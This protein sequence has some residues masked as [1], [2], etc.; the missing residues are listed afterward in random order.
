MRE[1]HFIEARFGRLLGWFERRLDP[2]PEGREQAAATQWF[3]YVRESIGKDWPL[4]VL[5]LI[6]AAGLAIAELGLIGMIGRLIDALASS[7]DERS[8]DEFMAQHGMLV[9]GLIGFAL[10]VP[11]FATLNRLLLWQ[12]TTA[13]F[14]GRLRWQGHRWLL[15]QDMGFYG[16]EFAGRV[17]SRLMQGS[18]ATREVV[19]TTA[20]ICANFLTWILGSILLVATMDV[21]LAWPFLLFLALWAVKL[22]WFVPRLSRVARRQADAR[23]LMTGRIVDSYTN[24]NAVKLFGEGEQEATYAK[25]A[26]RDFLH[27]VYP[28][29]RLVT[30][31]FGLLDLIN[32]ALMAVLVWI[33]ID[34]WLS[35]AANAGAV[36]VAITI[37]LRL[38]GLT[39]WISGVL[40][41]LYESFGIMLDSLGMLARQRALDDTE[42]ATA[43]EWQQ[44]RIE[45][46]NVRFHYGRKQSVLESLNLVV[47]PGE[48]LGL[49]GQ[50]G[51]GKTTMVNLLLRLYDVESGA[52][53]VDG[54]DI[55]TVTQDSLRRHIGMVSQD[56]ALLHRS[57]RENIAYGRPDA[58]E[59]QILAAAKRARADEFIQDLVDSEGRRGLDAHVGERGIKLSG[60]QR[61]RIAIAR[62][63]L[64]DAPLLILDE[65]TSALDSETEIAIQSS[66][67]ALMQDKT[68]IAIAHRLSTIAAMDRLVVLDAGRVVEAGSHEELIA[69]GGRYAELWARQSGGFIAS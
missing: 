30:G 28:Q 42:D 19:V 40:I 46:D 59:A 34:S 38:N 55:R 12:S 69:A 21:S 50:S 16:D 11:I 68:V 13:N 43:I 1:S 15:G 61:Q 24:I 47:E 10:A 37:G 23:A 3:R 48:R 54:Q 39:H 49:V 35:G 17:S 58:T 29:F 8:L 60:G 25:R 14:S 67:D 41:G 56:S 9:Y 62:V 32:A 65:A 7:A 66:L 33:G 2:F 6:S 26:M 45:F 64:K 51:A 5:V 27:T 22:V 52:I 57:V 20:D 18:V 4:V 31:M 63:F 53:R 44:G 36:A